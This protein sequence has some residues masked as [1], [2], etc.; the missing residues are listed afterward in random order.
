MEFKKGDT[1]YILDYPFGRPIKVFGKIVGILH[2]DYYNVLI[3]SGLH[4]G[5]IKRFKYWLLKAKDD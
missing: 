5:Q 3:E 1:V 2:N 4:E